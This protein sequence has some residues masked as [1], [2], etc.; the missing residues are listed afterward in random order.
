M[1]D[2]LAHQP[3][4]DSVVDEQIRRPLLEHACS[5]SVLDVVAAAVLEDDALDPFPLEQ[6]C[7]RQPRRPGA[8]DAHLRPLR[9]PPSSRT[10]WKTAKAWFA[11]GTP[12]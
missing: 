5:N 12:Q 8:D 11:A 3:L 2:P 10:P 6:A 1:H 9:R 4:A 7:E